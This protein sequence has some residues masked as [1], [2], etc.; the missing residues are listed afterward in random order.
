[1]RA[2]PLS[3]ALLGIASLVVVGLVGPGVASVSLVRPAVAAASLAKVPSAGHAA[4]TGNA[5]SELDAVTI[6]SL[7]GL[8]VSDDPA[9]LADGTTPCEAALYGPEGFSGTIRYGSDQAGSQAHLVAFICALRTGASANEAVIGTYRLSLSGSGLGSLSYSY[10]VTEQAPC[11]N[12]NAQGWRPPLDNIPTF[13][14]PGDGVVVY[15]LSIEGSSA[16]DAHLRF[17]PFGSV[18]AHAL[19]FDD[20]QDSDAE[21]PGVPPPPPPP[22]IPEAPL[23]ILLVLSALGTTAWLTARRGVGRKHRASAV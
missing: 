19:D 15:S 17:A 3:I 6:Q 23:A 13:A 10:P 5:G 4:S 8:C 21:S 12:S 9:R 22:V 7:N 16:A 11:A 14:V 2:R 20:D 1:M 18:R